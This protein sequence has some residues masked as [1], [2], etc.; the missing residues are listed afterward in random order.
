MLIFLNWIKF[1]RKWFINNISFMS[2]YFTSIHLQLYKKKL[3]LFSIKKIYLL[4]KNN[5]IL[6]IKHIRMKF[7]FG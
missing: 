1:W 4:F 6:S 5:F 2:T 7:Q 3:Y